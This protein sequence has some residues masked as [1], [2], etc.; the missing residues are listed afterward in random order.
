MEVSKR[1]MGRGKVEG[2]IEAC[3]TGNVA[4]YGLT[5]E[6]V[7]SFQAALPVNVESTVLLTHVNVGK[8]DYYRRRCIKTA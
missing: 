6:A 5:A 3:P 4:G 7:L 2:N 1:G 8:E